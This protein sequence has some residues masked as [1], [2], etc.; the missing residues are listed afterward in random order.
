M[1]A[2][3]AVRSGVPL[4][5]FRPQARSAAGGKDSAVGTATQLPR[6]QGGRS[7]SSGKVKNVPCVVQTGCGARPVG[8]SPWGKADLA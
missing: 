6:Q 1:A 5:A 7:S 3:S 2:R 8:C 4:P